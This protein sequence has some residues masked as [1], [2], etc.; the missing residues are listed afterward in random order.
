[1][2]LGW[3]LRGPIPDRYTELKYYIDATH[4]GYDAIRDA[5]YTD[6]KGRDRVRYEITLPEGTDVDKVSV[7]AT[8]YY[9]AIPPYWL[10]QRFEA[11][12]HM[13]ATQRLYHIASHLNL[14][15]TLLEDWK[16][17]LASATAKP[18]R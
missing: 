7:R 3:Q 12:P 17:R 2:P 10:R 6:G 16:L 11:A 15:G 18:S 14:D 1:M 13:P 9:Q 8:L 5:D 4:P